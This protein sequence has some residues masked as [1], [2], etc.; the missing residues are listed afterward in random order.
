[1]RGGLRPAVLFCAMSSPCQHKRMRATVIFMEPTQPG[2]LRHA[3]LM[4]QCHECD[5]LF[6]FAG[7]IPEGPGVHLSENRRELRLA[8]IEAKTGMVQ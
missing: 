6:E 7:N 5:Q 2:Q 4:I 1:M 8:I 3:A